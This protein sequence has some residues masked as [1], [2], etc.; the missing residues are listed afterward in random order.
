MLVEL[1]RVDL[2]LGGPPLLDAV[3]LGVDRGS[4]ICVLGRN[5]CGKSTML[6]LLAGTIAPDDGVRLAA[7]TV[8]I[9]FLPQETRDDA[10]EA[11]RGEALDIVLA[12]S[13]GL[14]NPAEK[15]LE[16]LAVPARARFESLSGGQ[17]RRVLLARALAGN[18]DLLLLDEPTNHLDPDTIEWLERFLAKP[19]LSVVFVSHD[20][21]FMSR[22]ATE[23]V[24]LDRGR[25][26]HGRMGYERYVEQRRA[27]LAAEAT[28][29]QRF[30]KKLDEEEAWIRTGIQARRT[31]N[32]G[33]VRRL[34]AMRERQR[35]YRRPEGAAR[36]GLLSAGSSGK[37]VL[38]LDDA[39]F[40]YGARPVLEGIDLRIMRGDRI[41]IIG[42]N[43][44]GKTTLLKLMLGRI[45]PTRGHVRAG[46]RLEVAEFDQ[47]RETLDESLTLADNVG[48][49]REYVATATGERHIIG[50]LR[51]FLFTPDQAR[52]P[53]SRLSGGERARLMLARLFSRPFNLLVM[54]EPTNDLD[55]ETLELLEEMLLDYEGTLLMVS[56]DRAF[57]DNVT[58]SVLHL[59]G[60]GTVEEFAG[61]YSEYRRVSDE[62]AARDVAASSATRDTPPRPVASPKKLSYK[63][64][65]EL[66]ELPRTI[67]SLEAEIRDLQE[68]MSAPAFYAGPPTEIAESNRRLEAL[69]QALSDCF[70]RWEALES[71]GR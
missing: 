27:R 65:R 49:G 4:R 11:I 10:G 46:T 6:K 13:D 26:H 59:S 51:E 60:N 43:G 25:L 62:R 57:L 23:V 22:V 20:R 70:D 34:H 7:D 21:R 24:E 14:A 41:G 5:G 58:T 9:G 19:G 63:L 54:D 38:T 16:R 56:H 61:G 36:A 39:G 68:R 29:Q 33:R 3:D 53:I 66:E 55:V 67:E 45:E 1:Q 71:N 17:R 64:K 37:I 8:R 35:A 40:D 69:E 30:E 52:A 18:P 28:E 42:A 2:A 47:H 50:Y 15:M 32:E 31:R 48:Q 44:S 12:G